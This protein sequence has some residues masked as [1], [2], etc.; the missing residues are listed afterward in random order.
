MLS[1]LSIRKAFSRQ[2]KILPLSSP[3]IPIVKQNVCEKKKEI[4]L[5]LENKFATVTNVGCTRK[6]LQNIRKQ[7][8][9]SIVS[10]TAG[11]LIA[12]C[13]LCTSKKLL[14]ITSHSSYKPSSHCYGGTTPYRHPV[15]TVSSFL[16]PLQFILART[17]AQSVITSNTTNRFWGPVSGRINEV[18]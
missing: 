1:P 12:P 2:R 8:F 6:Q 13:S 5:P 18:Q 4:V 7:S 10:T 17:K 16:R 14:R 15:N 3:N 11:A 9:R